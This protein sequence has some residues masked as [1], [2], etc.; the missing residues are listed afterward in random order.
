MLGQE[1]MW[2]TGRANASGRSQ[3]YQ[4]ASNP[5]PTP[6]PTQPKPTPT[7]K[8]SSPPNEEVDINS[9]VEDMA[10][11][12]DEEATI[13]NKAPEDRGGGYCVA[14][15]AAQAPTDVFCRICG[16]KQQQ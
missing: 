14:C 1:A 13:V 8:S 16:L 3:N 9:E 5:Y 7:A 15:G 2:P 10:A 11:D 6:P 12:V 4:E